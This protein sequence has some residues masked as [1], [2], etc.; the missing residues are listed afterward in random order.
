MSGRFALRAAAGVALLLAV[1]HMAGYPWTPAKD[2]ASL[3]LLAAMRGT[4]FDVMGLTRSYFDFYV[5]F[6]WLL[7]VYRFVHAVLYWLLA[8]IDRPVVPEVRAVLAVFFF[9]ALG[10]V[11]LSAV[12]LFW[13]P[14]IMNAVIALLVGTAFLRW[15]RDARIVNYAVK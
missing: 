2:S 10:I 11:W 8:A 14:L 4:H 1:G 3:A 6:G 9:E 15:Q 12:Y 5:G 7:G 13:V